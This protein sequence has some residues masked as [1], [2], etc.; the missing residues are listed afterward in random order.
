MSFS[1]LEMEQQ[2]FKVMEIIL[3]NPSE[4]WPVIAEK[5]GLEKEPLFDILDFLDREGYLANINFS[6]GKKNRILI[7]FLE[8]ASITEKGM[9]FMKKM[10]GESEKT[11]IIDAESSSLP[12]VFISYNWDNDNVASEV[13]TALSGKAVVC[14]DKKDIPDWGSLSDF[15]KSIRKQ[16]FAVLVI[17]EPYLKSSACLFEV[18]QLM[19]D[20]DWNEKAMYVV[21]RGSNIYNSLGRADYISYWAEH[22]KK[23]DATITSLPASAASELNLDLRKAVTIRDNIGEFLTKV[24][25][26]SNPDPDKVIRAIISRVESAVSDSMPSEQEDT[27]RQT[28]RLSKEAASI[29]ITAANGDMG[30]IIS[31]TTLSS[32]SISINDKAFVDLPCAEG[33][34]VALW[35]GVIDNLLNLGLIEDKN[36]KGEL[37]GLTSAG[38]DAADQYAAQMNGEKLTCPQ[39]NYS[40]PTIED[41]V[42]PICGNKE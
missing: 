36:Y 25:D 40:G 23:L 14:R 3:S 33:R 41:G 29:L 31:S 28:H 30:I 1:P 7:P 35:K 34:E 2:V 37:F 10:Q 32:Y 17:S 11:S 20:E 38:Y 13:E 19:K 12:S 24:A 6:R 22:C 15:M 39:C 4:R 21:L 42:C 26:T 5:A 16:D 18:M 9:S 27:T 8:N